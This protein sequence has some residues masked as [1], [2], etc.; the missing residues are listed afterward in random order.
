MRKSERETPNMEICGSG[1]GWWPPDTALDSYMVA[2]LPAVRT[3]SMG[4]GTLIRTKVRHYS[5][6]RISKCAYFKQQQ[7]DS[8]AIPVV[9]V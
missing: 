4:A 6:N 9:E 5:P 3:L 1:G 7:L 2:A 8:S